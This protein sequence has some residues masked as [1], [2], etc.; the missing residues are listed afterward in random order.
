MEV[1]S[2]TDSVLFQDQMVWAIW[3]QTGLIAIPALILIIKLEWNDLMEEHF[4]W[5]RASAT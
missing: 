3:I 2:M 5:R 1:I 4:G